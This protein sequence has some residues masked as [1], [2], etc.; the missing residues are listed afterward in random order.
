MRWT[1]TGWD[2]IQMIMDNVVAYTGNASS[3]MAVINDAQKAWNLLNSSK[4][5]WKLEKNFFGQDRYWHTFNNGKVIY[6]TEDAQ[7]PIFVGAFFARP[8]PL[9]V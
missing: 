6:W 5:I 2:N 3:G 8:A 4:A 7:G 1:Q 9:F